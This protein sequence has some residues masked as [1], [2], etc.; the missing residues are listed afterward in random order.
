[1]KPSERNAIQTKIKATKNEARRLKET[2]SRFKE[3]T[4]AYRKIE[5][6]LIQAEK[7]LIELE[8]EFKNR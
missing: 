7:R 1:M 8:T 5:S 6:D 2:L 3:G 4:L